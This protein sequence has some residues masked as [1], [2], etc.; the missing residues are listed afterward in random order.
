[1]TNQNQVF[2]INKYVVFMNKY[3]N[4]KYWFDF[5]Y[6]KNIFMQNQVSLHS[7]ISFLL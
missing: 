3:I 5:L 4:I 2:Q 1:M 6:L 7:C